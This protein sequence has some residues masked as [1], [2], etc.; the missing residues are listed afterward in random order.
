[1]FDGDDDGRP[2]RV[3]PIDPV[4]NRTYHDWHVLVPG[5]QQDPL[6]PFNEFR[7]I[8]L[9]HFLISWKHIRIFCE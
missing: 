2:A 8:E 6:G 3:I 1:M 9:G 5:T 4:A 7:D